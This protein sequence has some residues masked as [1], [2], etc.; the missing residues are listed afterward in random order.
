M[1]TLREIKAEARLLTDMR[2]MSA[3]QRIQAYTDHPVEE[4]TL[5]EVVHREARLRAA[6][7]LRAWVDNPSLE[8]RHN[9]LRAIEALEVAE[10]AVRVAEQQKP[11][12]QMRL[13]V[14]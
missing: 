12:G 1:T 13:E 2:E 10:R 14:A 7:A 11:T 6:A 5:R 8:T 4:M 9:F 3:R